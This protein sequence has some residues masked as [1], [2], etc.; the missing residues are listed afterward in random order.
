MYDCT[1]ANH[2]RHQKGP[3]GPEL[4]GIAGIV[5]TLIL[6]TAAVLKILF[7]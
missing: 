7:N 1:R 5:V 2:G 6:V 3:Q 4:L